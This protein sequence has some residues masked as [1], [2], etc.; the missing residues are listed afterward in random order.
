MVLAIEPM[1]VIGRPG[2]KKSAD[3]FAYQ[4]ADNSWSAHFEHTVA[5]TEKGPRVLTE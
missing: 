1:V 3:G 2:I 4:T 5:V